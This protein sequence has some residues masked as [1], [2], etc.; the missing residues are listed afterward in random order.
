MKDFLKNNGL[1]ILFAG[2]VIAVALALLSYFSTNTSPLV[3][4]ANTITSPFRAVCTSVAGWFVDKQNYYEDVTA[5][6][7]ENEALKQQIAEMEATVRQGEADSQENVF[8][9]DLLDLR[10]Q[11]RDL[12]DFETATVMERSVTNWTSSLTLDKG[13]VHGVEEGDCVI[14]GQG[15][16]VGRISEVGY[17]WSTVLTVVDTDTSLGA[18]V[19]RT[20]DIGIANGDFALMERGQLRLDSLPVSSQLLE[21]DLIVT[22]G[23]GGYLP[24]DLVIGSVSSLQADDSDTAVYAVLTPAADLGSLTEVC[25]IKSFEIVS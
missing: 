15:N 11:R 19:Y 17:N 18:R 13:S 7:E 14:D 3:D 9:R 8:L 4:L 6:K 1:W 24:P 23:L 12:S 22:S 25:I 16:L 2:A 21:G 10:K 20:Q 5:L